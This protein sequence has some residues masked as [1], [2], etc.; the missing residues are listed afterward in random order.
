MFRYIYFCNHQLTT[1]YCM[2]LSTIS[3]FYLFLFPEKLFDFY[4]DVAICQTIK[5]GLL[6]VFSSNW[7]FVC[8][9]ELVVVQFICIC[10]FVNLCYCRR[11]IS[12]SRV[13]QTPLL[14]SKCMQCL[15]CISWIRVCYYAISLVHFIKYRM[16]EWLCCAICEN[17]SDCIGY[18]IHWFY[19]ACEQLLLSILLHDG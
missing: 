8:H 19:P 13:H 17:H 11:C 16:G 3:S 5:A 1:S 12:S 15:Y 18:V 9:H 7:K 2:C 4:H 10:C 14:P 6:F